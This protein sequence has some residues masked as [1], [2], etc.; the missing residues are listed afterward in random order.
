LIIAQ[1]GIAVKEDRLLRSGLYGG[2]NSR[3]ARFL[4][5]SYVQI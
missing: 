2:R 3:A 5:G 1:Q 4:R